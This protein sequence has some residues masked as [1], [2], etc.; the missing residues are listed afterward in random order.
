MNPSSSGR[1]KDQGLEGSV[2]PSWGHPYPTSYYRVQKKHH[3]S[4][5]SSLDRCEIRT[6]E[7]ESAWAR[8]SPDRCPSHWASAP[9]SSYITSTHTELNHMPSLPLSPLH[10]LTVNP[11]NNLLKKVLLL[12]P[13][14]RVGNWGTERLRNLVKVTELVSGQAG[15]KP[16]QPGSIPLVLQ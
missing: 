4:Q 3:S 14:Y 6:P 5:I 12:S 10:R 9:Q 16:R 8:D 11:H 7:R 15:V 13:F 2:T 1:S